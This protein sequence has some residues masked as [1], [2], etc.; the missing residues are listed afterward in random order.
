[1]KKTRKALLQYKV[2]NLVMAGGVAANKRLRSDLEE[3]AKE[4]G[5]NFSVP[6]FKYC[7]DNAYMIA[8]AAYYAYKKNI[9]ADLSLNAKAVD[10]LYDYK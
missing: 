3:L 8:S 2:S 5:I 1:M 10:S 9:V 7:T 4:L 6:D